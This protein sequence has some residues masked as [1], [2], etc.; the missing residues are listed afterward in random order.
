MFPALPHCVG[1]GLG[2]CDGAGGSG[3]HMEQTIEDYM[4]SLEDTISQARAILSKD[5]S[6]SAIKIWKLEMLFG[7]LP[8]KTL[9][10]G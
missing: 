9:K 2:W 10:T 7:P 1:S 6:I 5:G 4:R 8:E 3:S